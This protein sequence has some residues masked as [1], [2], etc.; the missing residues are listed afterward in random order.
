LC[1]RLLGSGCCVP[2]AACCRATGW[3]QPANK[4]KRPTGKAAQKGHNASLT[5]AVE[6]ERPL[7]TGASKRGRRQVQ[8]AS[9]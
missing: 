9:L 2:A 5:S 8:G 7:Q 4:Q 1:L 6:L 3:W